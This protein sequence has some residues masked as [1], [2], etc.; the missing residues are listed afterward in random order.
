MY[1]FISAIHRYDRQNHPQT[2]L[3]L[4]TQTLTQFHAILLPLLL[5]LLPTPTTSILPTLEIITHP[6]STT[7]L[8]SQALYGPLPSLSASPLKP[9][10]T[11]PGLCSDLD[12]A[13]DS[14]F[15]PPSGNYVLLAPRGNCTFQHKTLRAEQYGASAL[16]VYNTAESMYYRNGTEAGEMTRYS[17][18]RVA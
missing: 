10:S 6:A 8:A 17:S 1:I 3:K 7:Y 5:S 12:S 4:T 14:D 15:I 9:P 13:V 11:D 16:V 2:V 18:Q